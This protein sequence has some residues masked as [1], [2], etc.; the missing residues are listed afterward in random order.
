MAN[1]QSHIIHTFIHY[2]LCHILAFN[3]IFF[4]CVCVTAFFLRHIQALPQIRVRRVS[5]NTIDNIFVRFFFASS[6]AASSSHL[7]FIHIIIFILLFMS[8]DEKNLQN[9]YA[10][11]PSNPL[12]RRRRRRRIS[13]SRLVAELYL[14]LLRSRCCCCYCCRLLLPNIVFISHTIS[15]TQWNLFEHIWVDF[16]EVLHLVGFDSRVTEWNRRNSNKKSILKFGPSNRIHSKFID[17]V[18]PAYPTACL[19]Q[20]NFFAATSCFMFV[21][22]ASPLRYGLFNDPEICK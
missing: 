12:I 20:Y 9:I 21:R 11:H 15:F 1:I 6:S 13:T 17:I 22:T 7:F 10:L 14:L 16:R 19:L 2:T 8:C 18:D 4:F 5:Q 3:N